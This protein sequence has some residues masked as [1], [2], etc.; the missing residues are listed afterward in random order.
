MHRLVFYISKKGSNPVYLKIH[1]DRV[2]F[3]RIKNN[4]G[5]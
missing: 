3:N 4:T 5:P 1:T 2:V